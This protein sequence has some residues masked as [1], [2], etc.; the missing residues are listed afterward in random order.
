MST[1]FLV[2]GG[3]LEMGVTLAVETAGVLLFL[4]NLANMSTS[5]SK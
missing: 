2:V 5:R 4:R 3:A 1:W